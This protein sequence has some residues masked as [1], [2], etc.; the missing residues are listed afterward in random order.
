LLT[1]PLPSEEFD[2]HDAPPSDANNE[3]GEEG[4]RSGPTDRHVPIAT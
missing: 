2:E 1:R 4:R 3:Q